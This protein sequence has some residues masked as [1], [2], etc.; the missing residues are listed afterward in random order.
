MRSP[1][2]SAVHE[3]RDRSGCAYGRMRQMRPRMSV[4][5]RE[6][7]RDSEGPECH[8]P[9]RSDCSRRSGRPR[10]NAERGYHCSPSHRDY[11]ERLRAAACS[12]LQGE[13]SYNWHRNRRPY[14]RR[15]WIG[16]RVTPLAGA[17]NTGGLRSLEIWNRRPRRW[18]VIWRHRGERRKR[19]RSRDD[20]ACM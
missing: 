16:L 6:E 14:R 2:D 13:T 9:C 5:N 18:W 15:G 3:V 4:V 1:R 19:R 10:A 17:G 7:R 8:R 12:H 11:R 20:I